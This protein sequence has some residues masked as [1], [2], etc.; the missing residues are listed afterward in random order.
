M[1]VTDHGDQFIENSEHH[2]DAE[3][4]QKDGSIVSR[5]S[6]IILTDDIGN[7]GKIDDS[8]NDDFMMDDSTNIGQNI[9]YS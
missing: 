7:T 4:A 8:K 1:D 2:S 3:H 5:K 9:L 6:S